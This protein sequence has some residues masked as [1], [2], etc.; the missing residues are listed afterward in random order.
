MYADDAQ[1][2]HSDLPNNLSDMKIRLETSMSAAL[3]WF[4]QNRLKIN[5][6]KT[7]MLMV[8]SQRL[9]TETGFHIHFGNSQI[10]PVQ[11][12]KVLGVAVDD[13]MTWDKHIS[14]I[15]R[16][17]YSVLIG[18]SR[19]RHRVPRETRKLLIEALV[20]PLITY[21]MSVWG[22]CTVTQLR[23]LQ[24]C[25]NFCV[26]IVTNLR[27]CDRVTASRKELGWPAVQELLREHDLHVIF[28][29]MH[30]WQAPDS[31]RSRI[32]HRTAVS[33]RSTRATSDGQLHVPR[34][35]TELARR[36][37]ICRTTRSW[38]ELPAPVRSCT[39]LTAFRKKVKN[40]M[41]NPA[42]LGQC[43]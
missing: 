19:I 3:K 6:S 37:F 1:F 20:F 27:R 29:L 32:V 22:G 28:K 39:S 21:C 12:V 18:L 11:S 40:G 2:L 13:A 31:I 17:C 16:R 33:S 14:Y 35:R 8:K 4:T 10:F 25:I 36:S 42:V 23:R 7:E 5:P 38:N 9:K 15:L 24:K 41:F 26:R 30:D 34:V 43:G